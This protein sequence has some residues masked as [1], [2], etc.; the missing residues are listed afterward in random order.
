[1]THLIVLV[2]PNSVLLKFFSDTWMLR[3]CE[4]QDERKI[5]QIFSAVGILG[6]MGHDPTSFSCPGGC[7]ACRPVIQNTA[8]SKESSPDAVNPYS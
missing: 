7:S 2:M 1:M 5:H 4:I 8:G 3:F 6:L